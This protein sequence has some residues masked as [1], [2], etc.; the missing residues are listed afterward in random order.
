MKRHHVY[1]LGSPVIG[2]AGGI[3]S[4]KSAVAR[5]LRELGC[6][7]SDA[8]SVVRVL[9][10]EPEVQQTLRSWWGPTVISPEGVT[11]R[12]AIADIVFHQP[13]ERRRLEALLHP[14]VSRRRREQWKA[15]DADP[16]RLIPAYVI[17]APLLFEAGLD[18]E[19]DAVIFV[20]ADRSDR[21][22]RVAAGRGWDAAELARRESAQLSLDLKRERSDHTIENRGDLASLRT[23]VE[24]V[25]HRILHQHAS[26]ARTA[27]S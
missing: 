9:L 26:R 2:L 25:L 12:R 24:Q 4:G 10:D 5:I 3:G 27:P 17:D 21:E 16:Q 13:E 23:Q 18:A 14:I 19:C 15:L 6:E 8:D 22:A 11:D 7:V 20:D 1:S